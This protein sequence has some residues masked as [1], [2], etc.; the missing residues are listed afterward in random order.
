MIRFICSEYTLEM[1][2][3]VENCE[4]T[5]NAD[6]GKTEIVEI[7]I[8]SHSGSHKMQFSGKRSPSSIIFEDDKVAL[9]FQIKYNEYIIEMS[10][11]NDCRPEWRELL[12]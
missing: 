3:W 4:S 10:T 6:W 12:G 5:Y 8:S 11:F 2:D 7:P 9:L 1:V